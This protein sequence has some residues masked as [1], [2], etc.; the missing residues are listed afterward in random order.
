MTHIATLQLQA[1]NNNEINVVIDGVPVDFEGQPPIIVDG[2]TLVPVRG[3]FE[4]LG[5]DMDFDFS[6]D[7][8]LVFLTRGADELVI[9]IGSEFFTSSG[10]RH[11]LDVPAQIIGG[12]T[13]LPIRALLESVGYYMDWVPATQTALIS[14]EPIGDGAGQPQQGDA[15]PQSSALAEELFEALN[16]ARAR[17][18]LQP[19]VIN[20]DL[21]AIATE[22]AIA[23]AQF[24]TSPEV[25]QGTID[26]LSALDRINAANLSSDLSQVGASSGLTRFEHIVLV[27]STANSVL[28]GADL[29]DIGIYAI[30]APQPHR[31][32]GESFVAHAIITANN[33]NTVAVAPERP[34]VMTAD[35]Q[36]QFENRLFELINAAR[37]ENGLASVQWDATIAQTA[38]G[39]ADWGRNHIIP[40]DDL[41]IEFVGLRNQA[42]A[43]PE[44]MFDGMMRT[45]ER[46]SA[47]LNPNVV[48]VGIGYALSRPPAGSIVTDYFV[49]L[50]IYFVTSAGAISEV[51]DPLRTHSLLGRGLLPQ[52]EINLNTTRRA[53]PEERA[54]WIAEFRGLGGVNVFEREVARIV[55][56]IRVAQG[57]APV[58]LDETLVM[59]ARYHTQ[60]LA[61][62]GFPRAGDPHNAG[63]YGGSRGT[64][65]SFG[66]NMRWLGGNYQ[67]GRVTPQTVV[68]AW[69]DSPG[70]RDFI[71]SPEHRYI[72]PGLFI[73]S[74]GR[75]FHYLLMAPSPSAP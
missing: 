11:T 68:D 34:P 42:G 17:H 22:H 70:H 69:M 36:T 60:M 9:T 19:L 18:G 55:S 4:A 3:V 39:I 14:S 16:N 40:F 29:T 24:P 43:T 71:L 15:L 73:S 2:R 49:F 1:S 12:R 53:T 23:I 25:H 74:E 35:E 30:A 48:G 6:T 61:A 72:G 21:T 66:A 65:D 41:H 51:A 28:F 64:A 50:G 75:S 58:T 47:I 45:P 38:R 31:I 10:V 54:A 57:L 26:G 13:L 27:D 52:S 7:T 56:E 37:A 67:S 62:L 46:R 63:P 44:E 32:G 8:R 33:E 5:F 20:A 59:V